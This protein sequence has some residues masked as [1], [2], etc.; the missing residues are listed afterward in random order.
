MRLTRRPK[1]SRGRP[2]R[3]SG[4]PQTSSQRPMR[5]SERSHASTR[6]PMRGSE[7]RWGPSGRPLGPAGRPF[8]LPR[9]FFAYTLALISS[10]D[11]LLARLTGAERND[12]A[13]TLKTIPSATHAA[14]LASPEVREAILAALKRRGVPDADVEDLAHD[15]I[16]RAL[17]TP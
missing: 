3:R 7:R 17:L 9:S 13:V 10:K 16:E 14:H 12:A 8:R 2:M 5:G 4:R 11:R 15:V 1:G 6:G